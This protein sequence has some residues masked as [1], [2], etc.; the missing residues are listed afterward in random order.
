MEAFTMIPHLRLQT[1]ALFASIALLTSRIA[2][3]QDDSLQ[4][5]TAPAVLPQTQPL[6][7]EGDLASQM[8]AGADEFLLRKIGEAARQ[9]DSDWHAKLADNSKRSETIQ[10]LRHEF[11]Q[12]LGVRD[13]LAS[14]TTPYMLTSADRSAVVGQ[15]KGFEIQRVHWRTFGD[16]YGCGLLLV[17][18]D[19]TGK[20]K[21]TLGQ[22]IAIP[23]C[24]NTPEQLV[25]LLPGIPPSSQYGRIL[26]ENGFLVLVPV[27]VNRAEQM[28]KLS[29]REWLYRSAF[30]LGRG[31]LAY[32]VQELQ[33]AI[34]WMNQREAQAGPIG[35]FGWGEGGLLALYTAAVDERVK[36]VG[37]SGYLQ[38]RDRIWNEPI[39]RNVFGLLEE[40]GDAELLTLIAPRKVVV[41]AARG[42]SADFAGGKGAPYR[43]DTPRLDSVQ[44]EFKRA[45]SLIG[46]LTNEKSMHLIVSGDGSGEFG[47]AAALNAVTQQLGATSSLV[48]SLEPPQVSSAYNADIEQL[49]SLAMSRKIHELNTH[50]QNLLRESHYLRQTNTMSRL[51]YSSLAAYEKSSTE[52][53]NHFYENVIGRFDEKVMPFQPRTRRFQETEHW[54]GYEVV[55]DVYPEV[56][57]YGLLLIPK[58]LKKGER[59]P[60]VVCQHGLEGRPQDTIGEKGFEAYKAFSAKLAERGFIT[61]APQNLYIFTDR[62]RSLQRKANPLKK[63]LFSI[64]TPQHQQIVDWLQTL[65]FVDG[66]RIGFYGLS[67]GGKTAMRVP[68]L[69]T[70]YKLSI[71]SADFNEWVDKNASTRNP[72]SYTFF[73]E[74]EIFE[75]DLGSTFNY[76]EMAALI[77]PR[78]FMVE[79]GHNDGVA[80]D[81]T[82][83]YEYAKIRN[84]YA[85][86]LKIPQLTEIE[87]FDGPHTINGKG[88]FEFLHR[89]LHWPVRTPIE[90]LK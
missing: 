87:W 57:A 36:V 39:D 73:G 48:V 14:D 75:F 41:E 53:R 78:P 50:S 82:V 4:F 86:K 59:R 7:V 56:F 84:L 24:E 72:R 85:A 55:L 8:V 64:I 47:S 18:V 3:G 58:D 30:E 74:Y 20:P 66:E 38:A 19:Q 45:E 35:V 65:E 26:A 23:D 1:L 29:H 54:I 83:A 69:V 25:G 61:F 21:K 79:R 22:M 16:C 63:S 28:P 37:I 6:L 40:F 68:A 71:C 5:A 44:A 80:D 89:H 9:R 10:S 34:H 60:V 81:W 67:Y 32:E 77:A 46:A 52:L 51:D 49:S 17:P 90:P 12:R 31:M 13:P 43:L 70:D 33:A 11:A 15:G 2:I 62:F 88:S 27:L 42:P 76:A